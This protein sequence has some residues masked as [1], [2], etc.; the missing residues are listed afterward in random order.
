MVDIAFGHMGFAVERGG[1]VESGKKQRKMVVCRAFDNQHFGSFG[2]SLYFLFQQEKRT[3][4]TA[5]TVA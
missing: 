4:F 2:D 1:V 5:D 3:N